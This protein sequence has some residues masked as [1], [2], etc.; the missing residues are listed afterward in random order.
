MYIL[1][2]ITAAL[3][4]PLLW[5]ILLLLWGV[6][7]LKKKRGKSWLLSGLLVLFVFSNG[8]VYNRV[9]SAWEGSSERETL[10]GVSNAVVLGGIAE[11]DASQSRLTFRAAS[12]RYLQALQLLQTG[13]VDRLVISGGG[14]AIPEADIL[15][16]FALELG[17]KDSLLLVEN[18]SLNTYENAHFTA[19]LFNTNKLPMEIILV[20]SAF[21]I[22]RAKRCFEKQGFTVHPYP[23]HSLLK[24]HPL[25]AADYFLPDP[26]VLSNWK[27]LL[28]EWVGLVVYRVR[29]YA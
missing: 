17:I 20:T 15:R 27:L 4:S 11:Y 12:D 22:P 3:L 10:S 9:V 18:R 26:W 19:E 1:S 23:T 21:H 2:K 28:K 29:G 14:K 8:W 25:T 6:I 24:P 5:A 16:N 7:R 13:K